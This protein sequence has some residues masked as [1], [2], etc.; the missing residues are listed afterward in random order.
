MVLDHLLSSVQPQ[1][2]LEWSRTSFEQSIAE[3]Y[4]VV[5]EAHL[6]G[7]LQMLEVGI[8]SLL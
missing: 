4:T 6:Q 7:A 8:C 2:F 1:S 5:L 3:F